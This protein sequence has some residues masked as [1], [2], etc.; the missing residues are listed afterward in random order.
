MSMSMDMDMEMPKA[1][2][3]TDQDVSYENKYIVLGDKYYYYSFQLA[4]RLPNFCQENSTGTL[5]MPDE[6]V[7]HTIQL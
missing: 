6:G 1:S 7:P 5:P 2:K 3:F 4:F